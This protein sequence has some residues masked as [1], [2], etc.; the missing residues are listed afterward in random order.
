MSNERDRGRGSGGS[1]RREL[2]FSFF[3]GLLVVALLTVAEAFTGRE[4]SLL[5]SIALG[6]VFGVIVGSVWAAFALFRRR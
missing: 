1:G 2:F 6:G 5:A 3:V 4:F